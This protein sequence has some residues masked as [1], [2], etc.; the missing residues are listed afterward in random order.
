[1]SANTY[2]GTMQYK[3]IY[4]YSAPI[5]DH[6]GWLKIGEHAFESASSPQQLPP[7]CEELNNHARARIRQ[8]TGT[9]MGAYELLHTE[10]AVRPVRL[11]DG[12]EMTA[13]FGDSAVHEVLDRS[14]YSRRRFF[15]TGRPSEW[16]DVTLAPAI[17]AIRAV[18]DG[19]NVLTAAEKGEPEQPTLFDGQDDPAPVFPKITLRDEQKDCIRKT[20]TVF[21]RSDKMLWD[22]KMR[23]GKTVTAYSLVKDV[24]YQ[25]VLVVT[26]RP[27]VVDGWRSDFDLIF[28]GEDRVFLTK[29][30]IK[31]A[32]R[33][34]A[35]DASIDAEN[36]RKLNNLAQSGTPFV[37]FASMQDLRG[38]KLV[39]GTFEKNRAV[40][41][42]DWDLIIYDE[43]HEGTQTELGQAVQ[44][45][46]EE[47]KDGRS[48]KKVLQLSGTPY[49]LLNQYEND[50]VYS[51]DY[52]MEQRKKREWADQH[53]GDHN[54]YADLPEL[55]ICTKSARWSKHSDG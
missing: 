7:N 42:M 20:K 11:L 10:L 32:D 55:R 12:T 23:F 17:A 50:D 24:G 28:H 38:S 44:A 31:T 16:F 54:P 53:P 26:H 46:L 29:A 21:H 6:K 8:Q 35:A 14:G 13:P 19:R 33:F 4:I 18:K 34:T 45:K 1:M 52:V 30:N 51:W 22:C 41:S 39:G 15:E 5:E 37:Y 25:K 3:L 9:Y 40:F 36:D 48:P 43:A 27:A 47:P 49:N 2:A